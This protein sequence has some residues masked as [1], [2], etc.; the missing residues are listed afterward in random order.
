[1]EEKTYL[2]DDTVQITSSRAILSGK[3]Y[4][5]A[6]ITS[7]GMQK[8]EVSGCGPGLFIFIGVILVVVSFTN[9]ISFG[10][11][12]AGLIAIAIA[13]FTMRSAKPTYVIQVAS[14]SGEIKALESEDE[15][16]IESV[17]TALND[18]IA[19]KP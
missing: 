1:M 7:V 16:Y 2:K 5:I 11:L 14:A 8:K 15:T 18:A 6:N 17:L 12:A 9:Q 3:T 4:S 13:V 10:T 19:Q